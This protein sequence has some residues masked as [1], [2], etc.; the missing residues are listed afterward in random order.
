M[1]SWGKVTG[2]SGYYVYRK[3]PSSGWSKVATIKKGTT[4]SY[5]D[6][7]VT[8][9][10]TYIYTVKAYSGKTTSSFNT[11]GVTILKKIP[12]VTITTKNV[13]GGKRVTLS[14]SISGATI[15]YKT[16]KDGK[17]KKYTGE[18]GLTSTKT[19]YAYA[20]RSGYYKSSTASKKI[21]VT[22]VKTPSVVVKNC[23]GGK[24]IS[25]TSSTSGAT[26]YY[27]TSK[28]G[29][30]VKY[31]EPFGITSTKTIYVKAYKPGYATSST[32]SKKVSVSKI[33]TPT[34]SSAKT[35]SASSIKVS[36]KKVSGAQGYYLYRATA[37]D[38]TYT[39]VQKISGGTKVSC[40]DTGLNQ[41]TTYYYKVR[42]YCSGKAT[43]SYSGYKY[44]KTYECKA[45]G[46]IEDIYNV[47]NKN[48][49][50]NYVSEA[51]YQ[52]SLFSDFFSVPFLP[53]F[54]T[55]GFS[56]SLFPTPC[57]TNSLTTPSL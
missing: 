35:V 32:A 42:A 28:N 10:K 50:V 29:S 21:T 31:T 48:T 7:K 46:L 18:F 11:N 17:Y 47:Y 49:E 41:G 1:L 8:Y 33:G 25:F 4:A 44:A 5:T 34:I 26:F 53:K 43:S 36:W 54:G 13:N 56:C 6:K 23:V 40:T 22:K 39:L 27:K 9:G 20:V 52:Y 3:T 14:S 51:G 19:I 12:N 30:Y 15:Y 57:P 37:K 38:G 45:E 55:S 2:A 24:K 16:S